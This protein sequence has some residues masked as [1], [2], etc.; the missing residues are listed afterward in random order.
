GSGKVAILTDLASAKPT[1]ARD[2]L[3]QCAGL[4]PGGAY[5]QTHGRNFAP[6]LG[7]AWDPRGDGKTSVRAGFGMYDVLPFP[8]LLENRTNGF[9]FFEQAKIK[10]PPAS[11]FPT[12][13]L[14]L[15][16]PGSFRAA[17]VQ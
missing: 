7:L 8:Y 12:G 15:V 13:G 10:K 11:A 5:F 9:P 14:A 6:R 16:V 2:P 17:Y 1:C 3:G 4:L